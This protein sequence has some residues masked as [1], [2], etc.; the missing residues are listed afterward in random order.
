[1]LS[2]SA[3]TG[4]SRLPNIRNSSTKVGDRDDAG[5]PA[6]AGRRSTPSCRPAGPPVR[7]R[8][9]SN[10]AST[11][12]TSWT[13]A[14]PAADTGSTDGTTLNHVPRRAARTVPT[15]RRAARPADRRRSCR[16]R[17]RRGRRPSSCE[18]VGGVPRRPRR[19]SFAVG[20]RRRAKASS[21]LRRELGPQ[22]VG[23]LAARRAGRQHPVVRQAEDDAEERQA[24]ARA[25]AMTRGR[26]GDRALH[27]AAWP[28]GA[29]SPSP[30]GCGVRRKTRHAST[31]V[32]STAS[33]A[34][35]ATIDA[36]AA[37]STTAMPA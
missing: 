8:A 33:S 9:R 12:R 14:S 18:T 19:G 4:T 34:G 31:R 16:S 5:R 17:R 22:R 26:D 37:T 11:A 13:S 2:T 10:G 25:A 1:M 35:S 15:R 6:A 36:S 3:L 27:H 28:C 32:P 21:S 7:R 29:R 24:E 30:P 23:H 20:D